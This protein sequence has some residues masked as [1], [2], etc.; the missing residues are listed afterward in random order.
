MN[1]LDAITQYIPTTLKKV[2]SSVESRKDLEIE[3]AYL[4]RDLETTERQLNLFK[5]NL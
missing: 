2:D 4:K 1:E 5:N 3:N